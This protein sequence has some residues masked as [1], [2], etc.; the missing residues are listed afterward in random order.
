[1]TS[2]M[3]ELGTSGSVGALGE[4]SPR[5]TRQILIDEIMDLDLLGLALGLPLPP[6]VA[7]LPHKLFLLGIDRD[8]GLI[9]PLKRLGSPIDILELGIPIRM[10]FAL[11]R[12]AI[13]LKAV[14]QVVEQSVDRPL[15]DDVS[16][17]P[18]TIGQLMRT[19]AR[20]PQR[21]H[22]IA[23]SHGIN[24]GFQF[25]KQI[26]VMIGHRLSP[27]PWRTYPAV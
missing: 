12:L 22:R 1:M 7:V 15:A 17:A 10:T 13:G 2:R 27:A 11:D 18:K 25:T 20:P 19:L 23:T 24:Q 4:Q 5:A 14:A 26:R 9:L 16:S 6:A 21:R 8:H 3:P